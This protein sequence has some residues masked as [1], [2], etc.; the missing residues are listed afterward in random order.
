MR[1]LSLKLDELQVETFETSEAA[2]A[3][4]TVVARVTEPETCDYACP[5]EQRTW[6]GTCDQLVFTCAISCMPRCMSGTAPSCDGNC[7]T[8]NQDTCLC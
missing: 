1:K 4:G 8:N 2:L 6:C 5:S 3:R 7:M